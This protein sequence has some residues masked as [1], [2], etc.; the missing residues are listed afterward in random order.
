MSAKTGISWTGSTWTPLRAR[1]KEDAGAIAKAKGYTSLVQIAEKMAGH[2]GVHCEHVSHGCDNCYAE[3]NN[4][5]CLPANGTG[6][7][8]D[9]RSRDLVDPIVDEKILEWPLHWTKPRKI[10]VN[11][12]TDTFGDWIPDEDLDRMFAV[13]ALRPQ[14]TFQILTKRWK[15]M[16]KYFED[17][18]YR[19]EMIGIEAELRSGL[20]RFMTGEEVEAITGCGD[21]IIPRWRIPFKNVWLGV[22]AEDQ[23]TADERIPELLKVPAAVHFVSYEPALGPVNLFKYM[24]CRECHE[25]RTDREEKCDNV[26]LAWAIIGGESG[27]GA[28]PFNLQ[29]ARDVI[30]Q[31]KA[32]GS[33]AFVKQL[34]AKPIDH[35]CRNAKC[36][37]SDCGMEA[38]HL[39]DKK[40]GNIEEFPEELRV[41][42]FPVIS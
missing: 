13:M 5:R 33:A 1:V 31:C 34:G 8:F 11:S 19:Q 41:R 29:W 22:S 28:R 37:H 14:H 2:V 3:T 30:A 7:P 39:K 36:T 27:S 20:D 10:F 16:R 12:Q 42:E 23:P 4:E 25:G 26:R 24:F 40:G 6:L 9:R 15:R 21:D 32:T 17:I 38:V 35:S 18:A